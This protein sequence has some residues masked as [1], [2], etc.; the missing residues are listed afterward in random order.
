MMIVNNHKNRSLS[1][2]APLLPAAL[3]GVQGS[4]QLHSSLLAATGQPS[5]V[6]R[7][8]GYGINGRSSGS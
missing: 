2:F 7:W 8:M 5:W 3:S 1:D 6:S 4:G